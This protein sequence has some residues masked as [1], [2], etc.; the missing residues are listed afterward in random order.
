M[1]T[2]GWRKS[3]SV[4]QHLTEQPYSY[5]FFQAVRLLER[6]ATFENNTNLERANK[7]VAHFLPPSTEAVRFHSHQS[8]SFPSSEISEVEKEKMRSGKEQ[9]KLLVNFLGLSGS[10]GVLPFHYTEL[11]LQRL[12]AKDSSLQDFFDLFNH[13]IISLFYQAS[14]KYNLPIEYERKK[15][16]RPVTKQRDDHSQVLL[17]LIGLGTGNLTDRLFTRDESLLYYSGLFTQQIRTSTGLKQIL[18]SHFGIP[19]EIKEF[20]GQW[21]DLIDDVRT[22]LPGFENPQGQNNC[23]GK[24]VML[25]RKG[26]FAQGKISIMLG[27]LDSSQLHKF[28]PGTATLKALNELVHIYAG[29]EYNYDF[30]IQIKRSDIPEKIQLNSK[31][32]A[33]IGWNTWLSTKPEK[34]FNKDETLDIRVSAN[35]FR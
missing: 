11:I 9:W 4:I 31:K 22:R 27:P 15:L 34:T 28:A 32:P 7:P 21:Q 16:N 18:S 23:L 20:I 24:S 8:L 3:T 30:I 14:T 29:M 6:S 33:I 1:S 12:K 17:S 35:R 10:C 19:V 5:S 13:R 25:G 2:Q 26:W